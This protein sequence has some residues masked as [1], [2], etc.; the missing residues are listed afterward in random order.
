MSQK[1]EKLLKNT[2]AMFSTNVLGL[3]ISV[4]NSFIVPGF[5]S[6]K[7][8][9]MYKTFILYCSLI[10]VLHFGYVDGLYIKYGGYTVDQINREEFK[11][12][13][14]FLFYFQLFV[15]TVL[16]I[17]S[18]SS[19][20][21]VVFWFALSILPTNLQTLM[22]FVYQAVGELRT[23][24]FWNG[25][26]SLTLLLANTFIVFVLKKNS[27]LPFVI[28]IIATNYLFFIW[29]YTQ[30]RK[31]LEV[32]IMNPIKVYKDVRFEIKQIFISGILVLLGNLSH[33]FFYTIDQWF[34]KIFFSTEQFA[35]YSF[36]ISMVNVINTLISAISVSMYSY[37]F[38][39]KKVE[40][41]INIRKF[42]LFLSYLGGYVFFLFKLLVPLFLKKYVPSL[43]IISTLFLA[44]PAT[45]VINVLYVNI[46][47]SRKREKK[48]F[49]TVFLMLIL[50]IITNTIAMLLFRTPGSIA[51]ATAVTY[52]IWF[53][54]SITDF[55]ELKYTKTEIISLLIYI[56]LILLVGITSTI[57][58]ALSILF[59]SSII[60]TLLFLP[61]LKTILKKL[62]I[63]KK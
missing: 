21:V 49:F 55:R 24:A 25:L 20:N 59:T 15:T 48:Y 45:T 26:R 39:Q 22:S 56:I 37:L 14:S 8:Y 61:E 1:E 28:S 60:F 12:E 44:V 3:V 5:L 7:E 10:G 27:Y 53:V 57:T 36:A 32:D 30:F 47:K 6:V 46:Y 11:A 58:L 18:L 41:L 29:F 9:G 2:I 34:I 62:K 23:V 52:Y 31:E 40:A 17:F 42:L 43:E 51:M 35:F 54:Y 50:S 16:A 19:S 38:H 4:I 13:F 63:L 33:L